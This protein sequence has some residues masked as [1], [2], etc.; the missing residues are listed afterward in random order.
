[1]LSF[2]ILQLAK[3]QK[4]QQELY[5]EILKSVKDKKLP[6][7]EEIEANM[8]MNNCIKESL[9]MFPPA[10]RFISLKISVFL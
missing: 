5:E 8:L 1:V 9:R 4:L 2:F 7:Y 6:T 3:N 10:V